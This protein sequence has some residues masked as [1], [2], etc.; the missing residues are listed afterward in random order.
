MILRLS[1]LSFALDLRVIRYRSGTHTNVLNRGLAANFERVVSLSFTVDGKAWQDVSRLTMEKKD[2]AQ[3]SVPAILHVSSES[4][5]EGLRYYSA[6]FDKQLGRDI[7]INFNSNV[8]KFV[9]FNTKSVLKQ[10]WASQIMMPGANLVTPEVTLALQAGAWSL[11]ESVLR[12]IQ[13]VEVLATQQWK[14]HSMYAPNI[15][16]LAEMFQ[17]L[18]GMKTLKFAALDYAF[19]KPHVDQ[20]YKSDEGYVWRTLILTEHEMELKELDKDMNGV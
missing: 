12:K 5:K 15:H 2:W 19:D 20:Y 10:F 16:R 7:Y 8:F 18:P 4:R 11:E 1:T 14:H 6:C 3:H 13:V 17:L 9:E